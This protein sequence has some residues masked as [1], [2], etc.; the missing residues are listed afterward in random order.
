[1]LFNRSIEKP[2]RVNRSNYFLFLHETTLKIAKHSVIAAVPNKLR[3]QS[4][5]P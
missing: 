3:N 2:K 1:M 5:R 4:Q